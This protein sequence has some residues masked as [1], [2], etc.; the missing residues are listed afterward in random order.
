MDY[1]SNFLIFK[2]K[3]MRCINIY[4]IFLFAI[5]STL[6]NGCGG[7]GGA[8]ADTSTTNLPINPVVQT[9]NGLAIDGYLENAV[10]FLDRNGNSTLDQGEPSARTRADGTFSLS[11]AIADIGQHPVVVRAVAGETIDRDQPNVFVNADFMLIGLKENSGVVSPF[12]TLIATEQKSNTTLSVSQ[13]EANVKR[14]LGIEA[15]PVSLMAD[16]ANTRNRATI[17]DLVILA[18]HAP[19]VTSSI[20]ESMRAGGSI[21]SAVSAAAASYKD[22][23][24][25]NTIPLSIINSTTSL[26]MQQ[27]ISIRAVLAPVVQGLPIFAIQGGGSSGPDSVTTSNTQSNSAGSGSSTSSSSQSNSASAGSTSPSAPQSGGANTGSSSNASTAAPSVTY[28]L[29]AISDAGVTSPVTLTLSASDNGVPDGITWSISSPN[30]SVSQSATAVNKLRITLTSPQAYQ[31]YTVSITAMRNG[32]PYTKT[33]KFWPSFS[34]NIAS[35]RLPL[36]HEHSGSV[37]RFGEHIA[38]ING[39]VYNEFYAFDSNGWVNRK[40]TVDFPG[41]LNN[42]NI[43][44]PAYDL[45]AS[46]S[47]LYDGTRKKAYLV[48]PHKSEDKFVFMSIDEVSLA[49]TYKVSDFGQAAGTYGRWATIFLGDSWFMARSVLTSL[50]GSSANHRK[51]NVHIY[52][53]DYEGNLVTSKVIET[54]NIPNFG[55]SQTY[56]GGSSST[57]LPT[58][59]LERHFGDILVSGFTSNFGKASGVLLASINHLWIPVEAGTMTLKSPFW[60]QADRFRRA[61]YVEQPNLSLSVFDWSWTVNASASTAWQPRSSFQVSS[62]NLNYASTNINEGWGSGTLSAD[63][64]SFNLNSYGY[65]AWDTTNN[66]DYSYSWEDSGRLKAHKGSANPNTLKAFVGTTATLFGLPELNAGTASCNLYGQLSGQFNFGIDCNK[67]ES[68]YGM[69]SVKGPLVRRGPSAFTILGASGSTYRMDGSALN[70][71]SLGYPSDPSYW[72]PYLDLD[73]NFRHPGCTTDI[74]YTAPTITP[75]SYAEATAVKT[76]LAPALLNA[77]AVNLTSGAL[78][79]TNTP[80]QSRAPVLCSQYKIS[81]DQT[82]IV[83]RAAQTGNLPTVAPVLHSKYLRTL[84]SSPSGGSYD[85]TSNL[86]SPNRGFV[87]TDTFKI[88]ID[89]GSG[90]QDVTVV[91]KVL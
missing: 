76:V 59:N 5:F 84:V 4:S 44:D 74:Q 41:W 60:I 56:V 85:A 55:Y 3:I 31:T 27:K 73:A 67:F 83:G 64:L 10:A 68:F 20:Q 47:N 25:K 50:T 61:S 35:T 45:N 33:I 29:D 14:N 72:G 34:Y 48:Y 79:I 63:Y 28:S 9:I 46:F 39:S 49:G 88:R 13:A 1:F 6:L 57:Y 23:I 81:L 16:Y 36:T 8:P 78:T 7:G 54:S 65:K 42:G 11:V 18:N 58:I 86:Y 62:G 52:K 32:Q 22:A 89:D 15:S 12:T 38:P 66:M 37:Y 82:I 21:Q 77:P 24:A 80:Y 30:I 75:A 51:I 69:D 87:G 2:F 17:P 40:I 19:L 70:S 43:N 90:E 26:S 71:L 53:F 91:V